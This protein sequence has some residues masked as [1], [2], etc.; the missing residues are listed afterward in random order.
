MKKIDALIRQAEALAPGE[1]RVYLLSGVTIFFQPDSEELPRSPEDLRTAEEATGLS[2]DMVIV[3]CNLYGKTSGTIKAAVPVVV[4]RDQVD[5]FLKIVRFVFPP[6]DYQKSV[7]WLP[8][9]TNQK[10]ITGEELVLDLLMD[11][12]TIQKGGGKNEIDKR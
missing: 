8:V 6:R 10:A 9:K 1:D 7:V 11:S 3:K 4:R 2:S 5:D 12:I